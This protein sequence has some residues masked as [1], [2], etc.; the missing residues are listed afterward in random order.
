MGFDHGDF[1]VN[2]LARRPK[3]KISYFSWDDKCF[4]V[5]DGK[6]GKTTIRIFDHG[7][8]TAYKV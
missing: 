8:L 4:R 1:G 6:R 3:E 5:M 7:F 2:R